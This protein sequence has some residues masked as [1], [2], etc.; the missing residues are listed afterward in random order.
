MIWITL[1]SNALQA[2]VER[3]KT[4]AKLTDADANQVE[5]W[6]SFAE[7]AIGKLEKDG[8]DAGA[9]QNLKN[10]I[11]MAKDELAKKEEAAKEEKAAE[12]EKP[13]KSETSPEPHAQHAAHP[14]AHQATHPAARGKHK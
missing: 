12:P 3:L 11:A 5:D 2:I 1:L 10:V 8:A 14:G 9:V 4:D 13:E 7:G 6:L